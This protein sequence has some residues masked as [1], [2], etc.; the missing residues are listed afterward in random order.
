M[1]APATTAQADVDSESAPFNVP[2]S[3]IGD[4]FAQSVAPLRRQV[5]AGEPK[6]RSEHNS[7]RKRKRFRARTKYPPIQVAQRTNSGLF[8][9]TW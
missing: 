9:T 4:S 6:K 5:S 2:A 1:I 8:D 7:Q 3:R